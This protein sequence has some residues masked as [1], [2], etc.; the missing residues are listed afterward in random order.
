[1]IFDEPLLKDI[2]AIW[3]AW[4]G[5]DI[6]YLFGSRPTETILHSLIDLIEERKKERIRG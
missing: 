2:A 3:G 1:M 6:G 5:S 4:I